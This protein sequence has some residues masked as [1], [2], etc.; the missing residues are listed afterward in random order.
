M[1]AGRCPVRSG[2]VADIELA[3]LPPAR[4]MPLRQSAALAASTASLRRND[5]NA[6][7]HRQRE[8]GHLN[9]PREAPK[10]RILLLVDGTAPLY[11]NVVMDV[12]D[13]CKFFAAGYLGDIV[14]LSVA[15][16]LDCYW[17]MTV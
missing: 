13:D 16:F 14:W 12:D 7:C 11:T 3:E 6:R 10:F 17:A 1:P 5:A 15:G 8:L 4:R 2:L 9:F